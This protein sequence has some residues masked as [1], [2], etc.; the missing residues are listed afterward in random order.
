M[1]PEGRAFEGRGAGEF[2]EGVGERG[3]AADGERGDDGSI[4]G[5]QDDP[6]GVAW[7]GAAG[8][9]TPRIV[10]AGTGGG[11]IPD[12]FPGAGGRIGSLHC[13][14]VGAVVGIGSLVDDPGASGGFE[15]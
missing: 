13:G 8:E 7:F 5:R 2:D 11:A 6:G 10:F 12:A 9:A 1:W 3:T 4:G 15:A 14:D